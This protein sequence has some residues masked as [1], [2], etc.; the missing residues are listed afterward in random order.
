MDLRS[1]DLNLLLVFEALANERSVSKAA[2]RLDLGQPAVSAALGRLRR[3]LGDELFVRAGGAMMPTSRAERIAPDLLDALERLRSSLGREASF[4]PAR[5]T[6]VFTVASTDYTSFVLLPTLAA[7]L[8]EKAPRSSL[9][10]LGYDKGE[11]ARLA[12]LG[13]VDVALG[14]FR[15]PPARDVVT[16]LFAESFVGICRK[17]HPAISRGRMTLA[18]YLEVDHALVS[19]NRDAVGEIDRVLELSGRSRRVALVVPHMLALPGVLAQT[20]LVA[21]IPQRAAAR[22]VSEGLV[23]FDLPFPVPRWHVHM[24]WSA[25]RRRE[26]ENA[27]LRTE[28]KAAASAASTRRS[29]P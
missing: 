3:A 25:A 19:V 2:A 7:A 12:D 21:A 13:T 18:R 10:V 6:T 8:R 23:A 14:V 9:R 16:R 27:W 4:V 26:P 17:S 1:L 11:V 15:S 29:R 24:L 20:D 22:F 28:V 5:A